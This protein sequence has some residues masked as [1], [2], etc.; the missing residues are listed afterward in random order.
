MQLLF[1][2]MVNAGAIEKVAVMHG[3]A[4]DIQEFLELI[5]SKF[6]RDSIRL[7]VLGAVIG[8]N[9][10]PEILGASWVAAD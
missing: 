7:G 8:S 6:P 1:D 4:S 9:G 5:A 10:G 2:Q 3:L